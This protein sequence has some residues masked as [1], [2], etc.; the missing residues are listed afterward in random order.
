MLTSCVTKKP[1]FPELDPG[2]VGKTISISTSISNTIFEKQWFFSQHMKNDSKLMAE[3]LCLTMMELVRIYCAFLIVTDLFF[4]T[5][6]IPNFE[7][8]MFREYLSL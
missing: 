3:K 6:L 8:S 5:L 1:S 7:N 2:T 4:R